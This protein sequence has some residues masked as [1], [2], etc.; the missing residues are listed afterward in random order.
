MI[1]T[2]LGRIEYYNA[3]HRWTEYQWHCNN[4]GF[5]S[6]TMRN[7][8]SGTDPD[9]VKK[10]TIVN[11]DKEIWWMVLIIVLIFLVQLIVA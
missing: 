3:S 9:K 6:E 5:K 1:Y 10:E 11:D 8:I 2:P 7:T 4:C